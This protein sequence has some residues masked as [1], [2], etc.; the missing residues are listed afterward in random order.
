M[1]CACPLEEA[2]LVPT[3]LRPEGMLIML[4]QLSH[5]TIGLSSYAAALCIASVALYRADQETMHA[6]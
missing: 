3:M 6:S 2:K 5:K 4:L 1:S